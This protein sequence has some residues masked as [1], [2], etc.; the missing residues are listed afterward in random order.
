MIF[1]ALESRSTVFC[2]VLYKRWLHRGNQAQAG[3]LYAMMLGDTGANLNRAIGGGAYRVNLDTHL[4]PEA[5]SSSPLSVLNPE[6]VIFWSRSAICAVN[7]PSALLSIRIFALS[8]VVVDLLVP[9]RDV[10]IHRP[11]RS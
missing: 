5:C 2:G 7:R 11:A 10:P 3:C 6:V 9:Y 4:T 1:E 8:T